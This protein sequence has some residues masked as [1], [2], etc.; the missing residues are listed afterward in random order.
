MASSEWRVANLQGR[1]KKDEDDTKEGYKSAL[2]D[3]YSLE[4]IEKRAQQRYQVMV[5]DILNNKIIK[6]NRSLISQQILSYTYNFYRPLL[7]KIDPYE[8]GSKARKL[9]V[10]EGYLKRILITYNGSFLEKESLK[11]F[12]DYLV[13]GCPDHGYIVDYSILSLYLSNVIK[14]K[15]IGK[16]YQE[17]LTKLSI[18]LF[19]STEDF[20]IVGFVDEINGL[21]KE[22][23][24][25]LDKGDKKNEKKK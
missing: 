18:A 25:E 17:N 23:D 14:S 24:I 8:I 11:I 22:K 2:I 15:D 21:D 5:D 1:K 3:E 9:A 20:K 10:G 16:K 12:V 19:K 6:I 7:E 4:T 13:H